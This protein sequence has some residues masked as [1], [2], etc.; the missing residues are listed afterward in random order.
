[1]MCSPGKSQGEK[2]LLPRKLKGD[3][4]H[5]GV[6]LKAASICNQMENVVAPL[7]PA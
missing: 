6:T 2:K 3:P 4:P 7:A 1:M 5:T